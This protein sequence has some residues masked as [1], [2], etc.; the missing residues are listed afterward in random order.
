[1]KN[2]IVKFVCCCLTVLVAGD[3]YSQEKN[4]LHIGYYY[5]LSDSLVKPFSDEIGKKMDLTIKLTKYTDL[6]LL[7]HDFRNEKIDL[8]ISN[9]FNFLL[10]KSECS[11][12]ECMASISNADNQVFTYQSF[13]LVRDTSKISNM[14]MLKKYSQN[15]SIAFVSSSSTSGYLLPRAILKKY[16]LDMIELS[17]SS[18]IFAGSHKNVIDKLLNGSIDVGVCSSTELVN[19]FEKST[20]QKE[21]LKTIW[22]SPLIPEGSLVVRKNYLLKK[23][24]KN[25]VLDLHKTNPELLK[26]IFNLWRLKNAHHFIET[27][28]EEYNEISTI[29]QSV[30]ELKQFIAFYNLEEN[31]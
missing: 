20:S 17:F 11:N 19:Y 28:G 29:F 3:L 18:Y 26:N 16:E 1:M 21:K 7:T 23:K 13:I 12:I 15:A 5:R 8:Y 31:K 6:D 9:T 4:E 2:R 14:D 24:L 22:E 27:K 25:I 10:L 30:Q